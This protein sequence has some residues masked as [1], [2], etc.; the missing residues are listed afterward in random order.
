MFQHLLSLL[1]NIDMAQV[2]E[3]FPM[4]YKHLLILLGQYHGC[5]WLGNARS[6]ISNHG[7]GRV[8]LECSG[9][10]S[11]SFLKNN[12]LSM[13]LQHCSKLLTRWS[14]RYL[15]PIK[16][17]VFFFHWVKGLMLYFSWVVIIPASMYQQE[18][19][20]LKHIAATSKDVYIEPVYDFHNYYTC[21]FRACRQH[22]LYRPHI[23]WTNSLRR[24]HI[25]WD[26]S[27]CRPH[28]RW[29]HLLC[30]PHIR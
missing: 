15:V 21:T 26:H 29:D 5:W 30:R 10:S 28:I 14:Y 1:F 18:P 7:I 16:A 8:I 20:H 24:P 3:I 4:K 13:A 2:L 9:F 11:G 6:Q 12:T 17:S 25:R 22:S 19:S 27:V 23:R